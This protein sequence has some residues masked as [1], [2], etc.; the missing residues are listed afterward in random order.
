VLSGSEW[1][2]IAGYCRAHRVGDRIL[3]SGTT[4]TSGL[5]RA[6]APKDAGAQTTFILDKISAALTALG[7]TMEDIVRTR[8]YLTD[9]NDVLA[10]SK[11]HGRVFGAIKPANTLFQIGQLIGDYKVEI[12]AEAILRG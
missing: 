5:D 1:E 9:A 8:V 12:E 4:A 7:A 6:V 3:V 2:D 10:V 11:A